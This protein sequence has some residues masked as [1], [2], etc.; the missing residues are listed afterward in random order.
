MSN[1]IDTQVFIDDKIYINTDFYQACEQR[2]QEE[3]KCYK[4]KRL[5]SKLRD[6]MEK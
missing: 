1:N 6:V 2:Y 4:F 3:N 5:I